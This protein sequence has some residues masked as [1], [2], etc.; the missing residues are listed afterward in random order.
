MKKLI[1]LGAT[2]LF[3]V[4]NSHA[5]ESY[6]FTQ[7]SHAFQEGTALY[8]QKQYSA[9]QHQMEIFLQKA[10][11]IDKVRCQEASY[12]IAA[13]AFEL[14][15]PNAKELIEQEL[16]TYPSSPQQSHLHYMAGILRFEAKQYAAA[17]NELGKVTINQL[18][19]SEG[20]LCHFAI[21][22]SNMA[23]NRFP[24]ALIA[25]K[26]LLGSEK[27]DAVATYYYGY[28]EYALDNYAAALP[29]FQ[30]IDQLPEFSSLAPYYVIQIYA[31]QHDY[32]KVR[33]YGNTILKSQPN[34][35][36]NG[37]VYR[38]LG[39]CDYREQNYNQAV[40]QFSKAGA[41]NA[42][43]PR[44]SLYMWGISCYKTN[45]YYVHP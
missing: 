1:L 16:I 27:Y 7:P 20:L 24:D 44:N 6:T 25:F 12:F 28:C 30:K 35:P 45:R 43:L 14:R 4:I 2:F 42:S 26:P 19:P 17:L 29:Y 11:P 15:Q 23:V 8:L 32:A 39:E 34:N 33:S 5:Q 18:N 31:K 40:T 38:L 13:C 9:A 3:L 37:E 10:D 36:K 21:G 41:M 22:Y